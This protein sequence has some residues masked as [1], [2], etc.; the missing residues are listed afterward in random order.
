[1]VV[2]IIQSRLFKCRFSFISWEL[3]VLAWN[4][5]RFAFPSVLVLLDFLPSVSGS[6]ELEIG[7]SDFKNLAIWRI[8]KTYDYQ[9]WPT[10]ASIGFD[11]N[12]A[13]QARA[14]DVITS[15]LHY[16]LKHYIFTIRVTMVTKIGR[17][18]TYHIITCFCGITWQTK[19][20]VSPVSYLL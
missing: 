10:G 20:V 13:N 19:N 7:I 2:Y 14:G 9:I 15:R 11:S 16:K 4:A 17:M 8:E 12:E 5:K 1:M 3:F 6:L 18:V